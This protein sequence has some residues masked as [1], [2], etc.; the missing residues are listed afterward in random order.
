MVKKIG[1]KSQKY[2]NKLKMEL[3]EANLISLFYMTA[4]DLQWIMADMIAVR[5]EISEFYSIMPLN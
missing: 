5:I 2:V 3:N 1:I 4:S